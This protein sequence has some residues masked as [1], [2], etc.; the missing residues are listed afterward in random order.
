MT[1]RVFYHWWAHPGE[2]PTNLRT[3]ILLSIATLRSVCD[4]PITVLDTSD[5]PIDWMGFPE[6]LGFSVLPTRCSLERYKEKLEGWRF[7]SRIFDIHREAG[8][9]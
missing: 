6:K 1:E 8:P 9:L 3:P 7:L 4:L 5:R 2:K